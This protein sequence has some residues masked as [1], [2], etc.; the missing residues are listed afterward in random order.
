LLAIKFN[1]DD[2][3]SN[4][5]YAKV[6]GISLQEINILEYESTKLLNHKLW[7]D[8]EFYQKYETYLKNYE[9]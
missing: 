4:D 2:Y 9:K 3:Y 8:E 6:G 1:E 5:Y 7:I